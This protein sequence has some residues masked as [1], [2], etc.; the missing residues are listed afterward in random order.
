MGKSRWLQ[1][2]LVGFLVGCIS[3]INLN[4]SAQYALL[5]TSLSIILSFGLYKYHHAQLLVVLVLSGLSVGILLVPNLKDKTWLDQK[6]IWQL[7][8][9]RVDSIERFIGQAPEPEGHLAA[10]IVLG[11]EGILPPE[12]KYPMIRTGTIHLAAVSGANLTII[13]HIA[14]VVLPFMFGRWLGLTFGTLAILG[15]I[16]ITGFE[17]S[18]IRAGILGWLFLL[19]RASHRLINPLHS[20]LLVASSMI[21]VN[22]TL[23]SD[24][25]FQLSF[26]SYL[27]LVIFENPIRGWLNKL[28]FIK[29]IGFLQDALSATLASQILSLPLIIHYF[30]R[31]SIISIPANITIGLIVTIM[32][33][34]GMIVLGMTFLPAVGSWA[35]LALT[36]FA[37]AIRELVVWFDHVPYAS[38]TMPTWTIAMLIA[39]YILISLIVFLNS[40]K[41]LVSKTYE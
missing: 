15:F 12:L 7:H 8:E 3:A 36:P 30:G 4:I 5:F 10:S 14:A 23:V 17:P 21:A 1:V 16:I 25:G 11:G 34:L 28:S 41:R 32:M 29:S 6:L 9:I 33:V 13:L 18:I 19:A 31:L 37:W 26:A 39:Y 35:S 20:A 22:P 27:G 38:A 40:I 24:I 2:F